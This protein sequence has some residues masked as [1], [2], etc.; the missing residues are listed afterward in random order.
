MSNAEGVD[1]EQ[2][3][4]E[5][6]AR[7]AVLHEKI[8]RH[9]TA[10]GEYFFCHNMHRFTLP[11]DMTQAINAADHVVSTTRGIVSSLE[12]DFIK[13]LACGVS[14][15]VRF[16]GRDD[17]HIPAWDWTADHIADMV[18]A[19]AARTESK[20][21]KEIEDA[22]QSIIASEESVATAEE[23]IRILR[24]LVSGHLVLDA[25]MRRL[26]EL[27][28]DEGDGALRDAKAKY[29][30]E[31]AKCT[32]DAMAKMEEARRSKEQADAVWA[33]WRREDAHLGS[34]ATQLKT[35]TGKSVQR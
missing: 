3:K 8:H 31:V 32:R 2:L 35:L 19:E 22:T 5:V 1:H 30:A 18:V 27:R 28:E 25:D 15:N 11:V 9:Q 14:K 34:L 16:S 7:L 24:T 4:A 23:D 13:Q 33:E 29:D 20:R 10:A 12:G 17:T 6:T 26:K 21:Q